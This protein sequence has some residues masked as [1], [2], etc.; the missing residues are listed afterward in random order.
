[1][2]TLQTSLG[3]SKLQP[4][5]TPVIALDLRLENTN[6]SRPQGWKILVAQ[7]PSAL[8]RYSMIWPVF[9]LATSD[10]K[11]ITCWDNLWKYHILI[12]ARSQ[13]SIRPPVHPQRR[14]PSHHC[15]E[16]VHAAV[17]GQ[18]NWVNMGIIYDIYGKSMDNLWIIY[19][20]WDWN[21]NGLGN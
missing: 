12:L 19:G 14:K 17:M 1:M 5:V 21:M 10:D 7:Q 8:S 4:S 13:S 16:W 6:N 15:L 20:L 2:S 18:Y 9:H 3:D 11:V